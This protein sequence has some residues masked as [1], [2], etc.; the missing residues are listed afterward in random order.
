MP[1]FQ[2]RSWLR[3]SGVSSFG[4]SSLRMFFLIVTLLIIINFYYYYSHP[5]QSSKS[6]GRC[7]STLLISTLSLGLT[8]L[9]LWPGG[10]SLPTSRFFSRMSWTQST[11]SRFTNYYQSLVLE[12][13]FL[14]QVVAIQDEPEPGEKV[15]LSSLRVKMRKEG[16][17]WGTSKTIDFAV[18]NARS[19]SST[20]SLVF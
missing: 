10:C 4:Q 3:M 20:F 13:G 12:D 17:L 2:E 5:T 8:T 7:T 16:L 11:S 9:G 19:D 1:V 18:D 14:T 15:P 6:R